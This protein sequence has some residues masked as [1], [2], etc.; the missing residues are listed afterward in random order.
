MQTTTIDRPISPSIEVSI[1]RLYLLRAFYLLLFVGQGMMT[2]PGIISHEKP[3]PLMYGV[4]KCFLGAISLM[5]VLGLR[6]PLKML[7]LLLFE[8]TWKAI[9]LLAIALPLWR[10]NQMDPE[11]MQSVIE[12]SLVVIVLFVI[13]WRY[14]YANYVKAPGDRWK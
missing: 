2:W 10:A 8:F 7:P 6:Y 5:A 14:V 13:P 3:W 11:T 9:W 1:F 4:A 12:C